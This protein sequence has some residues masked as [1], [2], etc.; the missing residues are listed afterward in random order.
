MM[1]TRNEIPMSKNGNEDA[2][3]IENSNGET[4][5]GRSACTTGFY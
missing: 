3:I 5:K 2:E 4:I 1:R